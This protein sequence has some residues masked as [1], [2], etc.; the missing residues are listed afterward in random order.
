MLGARNILVWL[1]CGSGHHDK[2]G[3]ASSPSGLP[4]P[5]GTSSRYPEDGISPFGSCVDLATMIKMERRLP[6]VARP[7]HWGPHPGILKL[8][9]AGDTA[10]RV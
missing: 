9:L 5:L 1:L 10:F 8:H 7:A 3:E 4:S 2:N 6:P